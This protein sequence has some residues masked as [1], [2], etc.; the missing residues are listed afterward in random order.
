MLVGGAYLDER[1]IVAT[2]IRMR[3]LHPEKV[4][5]PEF[6]VCTTPID[7]EDSVWVRGRNQE[8]RGRPAPADH[9]QFIPIRD[10]VGPCG[11]GLARQFAW[12]DQTRRCWRTQISDA[13][14]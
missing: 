13:S 5:L 7:A 14:A 2:M 9:C 3:I 10:V 11:F 8:F 6:L 1:R 4:G 12:S